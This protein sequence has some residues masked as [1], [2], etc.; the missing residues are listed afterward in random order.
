MN[1]TLAIA[2]SSD[3]LL[4]ALSQLDAAMAVVIRHAG[5]GCGPE[6]ERRLDS[7][8]RGLRVL[9][10]SSAA[11]VVGDVVEAAKRVLTAADPEAPLLMLALARKTLAA[12]VHRQAARAT[13]KVA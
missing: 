8:S 10:G 4:R 13:P 3:E 2:A 9:L 1:D 12:V 5:E 7:A 6:C 11:Q